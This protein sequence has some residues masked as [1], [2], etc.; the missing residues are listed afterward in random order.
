MRPRSSTGMVAASTFRIV[1]A[2]RMRQLALLRAV[3]A[4]RG[5]ITWSLAAEG[6][7]TG[8]VTGLAGVLLALGAGQ[9]LPRVVAAFGPHIAAPGLP[10]RPALLTVL[11]AV[12]LTVVAVVAPAFTAGKVS[13]LEALR[14]AGV[15][16]GRRDI[17]KLRWAFGLLLAA[18]AG[19]VA[20]F[21]VVNLPGRNPKRSSP[22][23]HCLPPRDSASAAGTWVRS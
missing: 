4:G 23:P 2:Q 18:V 22:K 5:G 10:I 8:F 19:L 14:G 11:L 1:F 21:V 6:A 7:L 3:G 12:V 9:L 17:G 15:T 16:G 20:A 13:P